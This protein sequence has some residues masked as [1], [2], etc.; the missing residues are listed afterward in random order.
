MFR[1]ESFAVFE[2]QSNKWILETL[3]KHGSVILLPE[4]ILEKTEAF[5]KPMNVKAF[6]WIL[7][8]DTIVTEVFVEKLQNDNFDLFELDSVQICA[9]GEAVASLLRYY[10]IHSDI[11]STS[12]DHN[13]IFQAIADYA[14]HQLQDLRFLALKENDSYEP[15]VETLQKKEAKVTEVSL[16][17]IKIE[18]RKNLVRLKALIKGGGVDAFVFA[19]PNEV[20]ALRVLFHES[21]ESLLA[22][23]QVFA[24]DDLTFQTLRENDL[25]PRYFEVLLLK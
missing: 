3:S 2:S 16:C 7:L 4:I 25:R 18:D 12:H 13:K 8:P 14:N 22:N 21:L 17:E 11:I 15:L 20:A 10:Q 5:F 24:V 23:I 6:D 19:S 1:L 9:F